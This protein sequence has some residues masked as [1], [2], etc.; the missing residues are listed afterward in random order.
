MME[1]TPQEQVVKEFIVIQ[2]MIEIVN[3]NAKE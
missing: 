2:W 1:V 3:T